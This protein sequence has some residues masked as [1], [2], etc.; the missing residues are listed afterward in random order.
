MN[1]VGRHHH[2]YYRQEES[3][4]VDHQTREGEKVVAHFFGPTEDHRYLDYNEGMALHA[5]AKSMRMTVEEARESLQMI[6]RATQ[7]RMMI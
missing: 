7:L 1:Q 3:H 6:P 5:Q 4:N 2:R